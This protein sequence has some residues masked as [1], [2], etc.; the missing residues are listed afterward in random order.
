M[1]Y[2]QAAMNLI[3]NSGTTNLRVGLWLDD[4]RLSV[5]EGIKRSGALGCEVLGLGAFGGEIN[6]RTLTGTGRRELAHLV[7]ANGAAL[8]ALRAD[9]GGRR[10]AEPATLDAGLTQVREAFELARDLG[11]PVVVVPLGYIPSPDEVPAAG[12]QTATGSMLLLPQSQPA[13]TSSTTRKREELQRTRQTLAEAIS[14]LLAFSTQ[15]GVRPAVQAGAE[16]PGELAA[17]LAGLD[18]TGMLDVDL[19]PGGFVARGVEAIGALTA[20]A[21][22]VGLATVADHYRG[23]GETAFG[24]GD[25]PYGELLVFLSSLPRGAGLPLLASCTRDCDRAQTLGDTVQKLKRLRQRPV[26]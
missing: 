11:A 1:W 15:L 12:I 24:Q 18:H 21:S 7:K 17:F 10:L 5:R 2:K 26:S 23:G 16:P 8:G 14:A 6:P 9:L 22:R 19:N 25:V 3:G 20:L 4:L 13:S